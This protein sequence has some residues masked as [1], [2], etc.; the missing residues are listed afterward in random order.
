MIPPRFWWRWLLTRRP[1]RVI[2]GLDY[3]YNNHRPPVGWV[4]VGRPYPYDQDLL[5]IAPKLW[6]PP[7]KVATLL[8]DGYVWLRRGAHTCGVWWADRPRWF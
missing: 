5:T 6:A 1:T 7:Y 3:A 2:T 8:R 4:V